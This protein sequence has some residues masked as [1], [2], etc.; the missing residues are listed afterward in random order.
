[1]ENISVRYVEENF[2]RIISLIGLD[3][4]RKKI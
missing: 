1:M 4:K 2:W 3:L